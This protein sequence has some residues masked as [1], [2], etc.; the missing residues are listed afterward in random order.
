[1]V[2]VDING[3]D[4]IFRIVA[5]GMPLAQ[6]ETM[7]QVS[8]AGTRTALITGGA[9]RI[10]AHIAKDLAAQGFG[11][12]IHAN[13]SIAG[14]EKLAG[15]IVANGGRAVTIAADLCDAG[16]TRRLFAAAREA[17]GPVD[18]LVNNASVFERDSA[19]EPDMALWDRHFAVHLKAPAL[20]GAEMFAQGDIGSGLIV[21]II[22][23]RVWKLTP[24][25]FSYTLSKSALWTATRTSAQAFA[26]KLRVNAI[27]PGPTMAN[28]RQTPAD[29][30]MQI[31][32]LPLKRGPEPADF[33][34]TIHYLYEMKS[35]TGQM[36]A[37][38]GGQHLAWQTPDVTGMAE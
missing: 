1:L 14:A 20:L 36:L 27:G 23:Q 6:G 33:A 13:S 38:D 22:D 12:V 7:Q 18:L 4:A 16:E 35:V 19:Q 15:Q 11:V 26:P 9:R 32:G 25:F 30:Q 29:F 34:K 3:E 21:N 24:D 17:L 8:T 37:L 28:E 5:A 2:N 31:D 10:G